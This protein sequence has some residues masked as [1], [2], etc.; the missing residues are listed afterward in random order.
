M[1]ATA[2]KENAELPGKFLRNMAKVGLLGKGKSRSQAETHLP[3][4]T[5][6]TPVGVSENGD[7]PLLGNDSTGILRGLNFPWRVDEPSGQC[8]PRTLQSH[9]PRILGFTR[10]SVSDRRIP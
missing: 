2:G 3:A 6:S 5:S 9:R 10:K 1:G 8:V 4:T 7:F